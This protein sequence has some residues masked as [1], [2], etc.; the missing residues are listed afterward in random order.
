MKSIIFKYFFSC[1]SLKVFKKFYYFFNKQLKRKQ[2]MSLVLLKAE[3]RPDILLWRLQI[4]T[5]PYLARFACINNLILFNNSFL[6]YNLNFFFRKQ[7][8]GGDYLHFKFK[9]SFKKNLKKYV[10]FFFLPA[11]LEIDYYSN[12]I[13]LLKDITDYTFRDI[14]SY[15]K[16][17]LC[18]YKFKDYFLK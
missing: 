9:Y 7:L 17:P 2:C 14:N 12:L 5:S 16:E 15:I 3:L 1:I 10:K 11:S 8:K 4:F 6:N 13:I 18:I